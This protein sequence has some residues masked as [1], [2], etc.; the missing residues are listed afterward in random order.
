[1]A[2]FKHSGNLGDIIAALPVI[3]TLGGGEL[4]ISTKP[5]NNW[6]GGRSSITERYIEQI[7]PLLETQNYITSV[8]VWNEENYDYD[9][10]SWRLGKFDVRTTNLAEMQLK[11]FDLL[12]DLS[13]PWLNIDSVDMFSSLDSLPHVEYKKEIIISRTLRYQNELFPWDDI[14]TLFP[15]RNILFVGMEDE[16]AAFKHN[17]I[18]FHKARDILELTSIIKGC[19]LF[20]G[21]QSLSWWL[22]EALKVDRWLEV[23]PAWPNSMPLSNNGRFFV[24]PTTQNIFPPM[25]KEDCVSQKK[26][27]INA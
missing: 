17:E 14:L 3:Q 23:C 25:I 13:K 20:I 5:I 10:D 2:A 24:S 8:K 1:M 16:Y 18:E 4:Y 22:A 6:S 19:K 11:L 12:F 7:R 27:K 9:L 21:N 26:D 15:I